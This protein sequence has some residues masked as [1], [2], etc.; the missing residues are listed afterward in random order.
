MH[1]QDTPYLWPSLIAT[2]IA[3][4]ITPYTWWHHRVRGAPALGA[5]MMAAAIW[6]LSYTLELAGADL[7]T[8][9]YWAGVKYVGIVSVPLAWFVFASHY[10]DLRPRLTWRVLGLMLIV[11]A[12]TAGLALTN[13]GHQW[14][15]SNARL[16]RVGGALVLIV[17][18]APVMWLFALASSALIGWGTLI[19]VRALM[20]ATR[21][22]RTQVTI[23]IIAVLVPLG[24]NLASM[25]N[26]SLLPYFDLTPLALVISCL[27]LGAV[28]FRF[29]LIDLAPIAR[30][31]VIENMSDGMLV[32]DTRDHII[33]CNPAAQHLL[34]APLAN[35]IGQSIYAVLGDYRGMFDQYRNRLDGQSEFILNDRR[36][37]LHI[38][39]LTDRPGQAAGRLIVLRDV[40]ARH[41]AEEALRRSQAQ[42][43]GIINTAQDAIITLDADQ[44]IVLFN[45]G[46]ER[47]FKCQTADALGQ[48]IDRFVPDRARERHAAQI[49]MFAQ[50]GATT[51]TMGAGHVTALRNNGEEFPTEASISRVTVDGQDFFTVILRDTTQRERA[52]RELRLQKQLFENLVAVARTTSEKPDLDDTL[53]NVLRVSVGL[54]EAAR[55]SLFLFDADGAVTHTASVRDNDPIDSRR[56]LIGRVMSQGLVGWVA[57]NRRPGLVIDTETDE[58]WLT[59]NGEQIPTRSALAVPILSGQV[60][61]GALILM[62]AERGH[63][64]EAHLQLMQA[65]ADQMALAV[66]NARTFDLQRRLAKQQTTLYEVLRTVGVKFDRDGVAR[67]AAEAITLLAGWPNLAIILPDDDG[68]HWIVRAVSGILPMTVGLAQP[69]ERGIIGRAF[70]SGRIQHAANVRDDADHLFPESGTRSKLVVPMRRGQRVLGVL[71]IDSQQAAAFDAND[72]SLAQS[73]AEAVALALDNARLYQTIVSE[74]SQLQ[75]IIESSR[76]GIVLL[77]MAQRLL[78]INEP[79]LRL[80]GLPGTPARWL[81]RPMRTAMPYQRRLA[82]QAFEA[83]RSEMQRILVG[84]EPPGEGE[85][86]IGTATVVWYNLPVTTEN[87]PAGRLVILRDVT[88]ERSLSNLRDD[89][90]STMVHDLRNPLTVIQSALELL[91]VD[92]DS[93]PQVLPIM[94]QGLQ[95]MLNLVTSILDVNRLESGQMPLEREPTL[96]PGFVDEVLAVQK[97]LADERSVQLH[98]DLNGALPSVTIDTELIGR[99]LQNLIGNAIKFTPA[100]GEVHVSAHRDTVDARRVVVSVSDT[101]PGLPAEVQARLFQ[102]FV[103]GAGPGRGSGL[104]LAFCRLAVEAHGG[105]I[106]ADS[107]P[108]QGSAFNFTLPVSQTD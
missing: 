22:Y 59:L 66:R 85:Y 95:R 23:L 82:P 7:A 57:R 35:L 18:Y 89:L 77:S 49:R 65:A 11:P 12:L 15:W 61:L 63:F 41:R 1:F 81:G 62:H 69:I 99:V 78:V 60:L 108:G 10:A 28:L 38:S 31:A 9:T 40:T 93:Q 48:S 13:T 67:T 97:V 43:S 64:T 80:L 79:A 54:T 24:I 52:D 45:A 72:I 6:S 106:W 30:T 87:L 8:K 44:R 4:A 73:L 56:A 14:L 70:T 34:G 76:D 16:L 37:E 5:L 88:E 86:Q 46:A 20:A 36:Y 83:M 17:D 103:R 3:A 96:L 107:V 55:G 74:R 51:R 25:F 75:A 21:F 32:L 101:G 53:R 42:L 47:M 33:D 19:M 100:G 91:E 84:D 27:M 26:F 39:P 2:L 92:T 105:R 94:R 58:R 29:R 98:N 71:N 104:G 50:T 68:T 90:T 102:K